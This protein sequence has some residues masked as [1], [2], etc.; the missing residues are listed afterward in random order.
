SRAWT[1]STRTTPLKRPRSPGPV[2][3]PIPGPC[4]RTGCRSIPDPIQVVVSE[5]AVRVHPV[6]YSQGLLQARVDA[7]Q[8]VAVAC[9]QL[10]PV[11]TST[12]GGEDRLQIGDV[13]LV[14]RALVHVHSHISGFPAVGGGQPHVIGGGGTHRPRQARQG[15]APS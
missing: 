2:P 1:T 3:N 15:P 6:P 13:A 9:V 12:H 10:P 5:P 8:V 11:R 4:P 14:G 7:L